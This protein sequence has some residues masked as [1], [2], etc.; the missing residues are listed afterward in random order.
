MKRKLLSL[1]LAFSLLLSAAPVALAVESREEIEQADNTDIYALD[2]ALEEE[3][4]NADISTPEK[5]IV[6]TNVRTKDVQDEAFETQP[7]V[8]STTALGS[9]AELAGLT[10]VSQTH[11]AIANGV[12]YD[13]I[14]MRNKNNQQAIGY[15]TEI[16]LT[17]NVKL[18][19]T[20]DG[21]YT[22]GSTKAERVSNAQTI[23]AGQWS[24]RRPQSSLLITAELRIKKVRL[25][26]QRTGT[27]S[28][29]EPVS[30]QGILSWK[31]M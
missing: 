26:W 12:T 30:L 8:Q 25:S 5:K 20:Y 7:V 16:D 28:I 21:Y 18:K 19:A 3:N 24:M 4:A 15:M 9:A 2:Q 6:Q 27:I 22:S 1:L 10:A 23:R 31:G 29:W 11:H 14:V 13:K 17:K